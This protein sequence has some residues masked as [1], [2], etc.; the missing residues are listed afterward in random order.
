VVSF[1]LQP[2]FELQED[3]P[4]RS[5]QAP[6]PVPGTVPG[7]IGVGYAVQKMAIPI[8]LFASYYEGWIVRERDSRSVD[9]SC[10][11]CLVATKSEADVRHGESETFGSANPIVHQGI[12]NVFHQT[13]KLLCVLGVV[14]EIREI[15]SGRHRVQSL[16]DVFQ[17]PGNPVRQARRSA[18]ESVGSPFQFSLSL[19]LA[20]VTR[21][22]RFAEGFRKRF[23]PGCQRTYGSFVHLRSLERQ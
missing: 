21:R 10:R 3:I 19:F 16:A 5:P 17:F 13:V 9:S 2:T 1:I 18:L 14:E 22:D 7:L 4:P 23:D 20:D 12:A 15:L 6:L 11:R 8:S